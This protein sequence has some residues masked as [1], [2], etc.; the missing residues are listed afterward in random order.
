[1]IIVNPKQPDK[2]KPLLRLQLAF[3][4]LF[5]A[6]IPIGTLILKEFGSSALIPFAAIYGG[7][8]LFVQHCMIDWQ[9][10]HCNKPFLRKNGIG[11]ASLYRS[12]CALVANPLWIA[13]MTFI[14][15]LNI[16]RSVSACLTLWSQY[17]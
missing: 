4:F 14:D 5:V 8:I 9:C 1:M 7:V 10:P 15:P 3:A 17:S 11:F 16:R 12:R 13:E 2:W 6:F